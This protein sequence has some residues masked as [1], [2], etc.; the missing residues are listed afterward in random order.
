MS[1]TFWTTVVITI[2][3]VSATATVGLAVMGVKAYTKGAAHNAPEAFTSFAIQ[4]LRIATVITIVGTALTVTLRQ[5]ELKSGL[6][7][8]L[9]GIAGY[10]L[11]GTEKLLTNRASLKDTQEPATTAES[12][13]L[14]PS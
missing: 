3:F 8:I 4:V 11:G 6:T 1:E 2:G 9:S 5:S 13:P 14:T 10:V 12:K 7:G